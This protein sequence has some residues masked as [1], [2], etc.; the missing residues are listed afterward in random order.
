MTKNINYNI[1]LF[2]KVLGILLAV[3]VLLEMLL[4]PSLPNFYGCV[5]AVISYFVFTYFF[6]EKYI[7]LFPFA[8]CMY[9]SMFMYRY[10][11]LI[12]TLWEGKPI[13]YGFERPYET[14]L[15]EI[16]LFLVSSLAFYLACQKSLHIQKNNIL[17]KSLFQLKFYE[18][19]PAI[20]W[21]MGAIGL[22]V[23]VYNLS[24]GEVKYGDVGGKFLVGIDY[25]MFAPICLFFPSFLNIR[26][27]KKRL[28]WIYTVLII[29]ISIASNKR[30]MIITPFGT[31]A[32]L[33]L[34]HLILNNIKITKIISPTKMILGGL[35]LF[36]VLSFISNLS[37]AMLYT[38]DTML[39]NAE[40]RKNADKMEAFMLTIETLQ[41]NRLMERLKEAKENNQIKL[42]NY[43]QGWTEDYLDNFMLARYA[44][45]RITD[46]TLY[47]AEK[48][49][50]SNPL[51][52]EFFVE[53]IL[54]LF[55]TPILGFFNVNIDKSKLE[56][57]RGDFL[58][59][60]S[61]GGYRVTSH[62]GDGLATFGFWY[63]PIQFIAFFLVFK[64]L[65]SFVLYTPE[66][67]R[68]APF[69]L[70]KVFGFL[71]MF[72]NAQG[73]IADIGYILRGFLQG[74]VT[75]LIIFYLVRFALKL[76]DVKYVKNLEVS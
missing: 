18:I 33:F 26:Y 23:W 8:F 13:T 11:P 9:L 64:L 73:V 61:L 63:F 53:S 65:N 38:R 49:G 28:L 50:Y 21:G 58:S 39:Y 31:L 44:N 42:T 66:G 36:F 30:H 52:Q 17:Q 34:L 70:M 57:S 55:P 69:A 37:L 41:N 67:L 2:K 24:T 62:V 12:A 19:T 25:L 10:L 40:Q 5:M 47:Y 72:R 4:F 3:S 15:Y 27:S 48:R 75:Y 16:L 7:R 20:L 14:F 22:M 60:S 1:Q 54:A 51:M 43:A 35:I 76:I 68:Y 56:F 46:Q 45:M 71:G 32:V 29:V 6:D 59:N 74:V